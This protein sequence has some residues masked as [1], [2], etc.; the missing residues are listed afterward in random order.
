MP[1]INPGSRSQVT[2]ITSIVRNAGELNY[3]ITSLL[4]SYLS[5]HGLD[6]ATI[7]DIHGALTGA[8][9]EFNRRVVAPY[10]DK[11]IQENSDVYPKEFVSP[12]VRDDMAP[13]RISLDH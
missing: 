6:Y 11:K 5:T 9:L 8:Q 10:E 13:S 1:Y 7:N 2:P 12:P 4:I 3:A